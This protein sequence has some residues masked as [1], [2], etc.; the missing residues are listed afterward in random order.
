MSA[1][2]PWKAIAV[3]VA[4]AV[5]VGLAGGWLTEIGPW[6]RALKKPW[7]QPPDWLFGPAWTIIFLCT[8]IS[9]ALAWA[10]AG[11][12]TTRG[13]IVGLF[14]MNAAFNIGWSALFFAMK[15][16]DLA[17]F[18]VAFLWSSIVLLIV[19]VWPISQTA[20]ALLLPYLF[21]VSFASYLNWTIVRLNG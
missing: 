12:A 21:W 14:L 13:M 1:D 5:C 18:E 4:V 6:Y 9:A 10:G 8:A 3:A 15:R 7:F 20:G 11:S 2:L 19:W 16:P 17:L